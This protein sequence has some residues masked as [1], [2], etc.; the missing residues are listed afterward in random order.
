MIIK[1]LTIHNFQCFYETNEI[2]FKEGLNLL[3]G[4][5]GK[6]K[7]KLFNA[8]NWLL[9]GRIYITDFGWAVSDLLPGSANYL[10]KKHE[11]INK[12]A[13]FKLFFIIFL[14]IDYLVF[15]ALL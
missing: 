1:K 7:S 12:R 11:L 9:F 3:I 10:M 5:G 4:H 15:L 8:F 2:S 14:Y 13:L 6:G